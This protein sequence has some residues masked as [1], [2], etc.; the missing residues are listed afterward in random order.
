MELP[1]TSGAPNEPAGTLS[2]TPAAPQQEK[3]PATPA[4]QSGVNAPAPQADAPGESEYNAKMRGYIEKFFP[5]AYKGVD[6]QIQG[7]KAE[8]DSLRQ[9]AL[10]PEDIDRIVEERVNQ[11]I[12]G[13]QAT[14]AVTP[15]QQIN[16]LPQAEKAEFMKALQEG[17]TADAEQI[18]TESLVSKMTPG[19]QEQVQSRILNQVL[20]YQQA[21][22]TVREF[23][24]EFYDPSANGDL[25]PWKEIIDTQ[26]RNEM[27]KLV[28]QK[29]VHDVPTYIE[30]HKSCVAKATQDLRNK[31]AV[32]RGEGKN[33]ALTRQ[34]QVLAQTPITPG[35]VAPRGDTAVNNGQSS[36]PQDY[37]AERRRKL[38]T[39]RG[40]VRV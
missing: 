3:T 26:A 4:Q 34:K 19:I 29:K 7:A 6:S 25:L 39:M 37:I 13:Q 33:E 23:E 21:T 16:A 36:T 32:L 38:D 2:A 35:Q 30:A 11:R 14:P 8:A 15:Q 40:L 22:E 24:R 31:I 18:L 10:T 17:R 27:A 20:T 1:N 5:D 9:A 28:Q 12:S